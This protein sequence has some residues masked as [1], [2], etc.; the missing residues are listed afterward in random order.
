MERTDTLKTNAGNERLKRRYFEY[1]RESRQLDMHS[2]D[3]DAMAISRFEEHSGYRDFGRY[4]KEMAIAFKQH[5]AKQTNA[6]TG[7]VL[8]KATIYS[9]LTALRK[10]FAWLAD[11]P[12]YR[13]RITETAADYF[14]ASLKDRT[15][16][17]ASGPNRVPT[18][19]QIRTVLNSMPIKTPVEKRDR[20]IMAF[21]ILTGARDDAI[22]SLRLGHLDMAEKRVLQDGRSVRTKFSKSIETY[23]FPVGVDIESMLAAWVNH[24]TTVEQFSANDPLFPPVTMGIGDDGNFAPTGFS[25]ECWANAGAIRAI[26]KKAFSAAG[27]PYF[28]PHSFRKTLT[29]F[30]LELGLGEA[31]IKAWSQ[32]LGH[33]EVLVTMRSYGELP[34]HRQRDLIRAAAHAREDDAIALQLG[35]E[36]LASMRAKKIAG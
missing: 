16:A 12:G 7:E 5:L 22:A 15:A 3:A 6:R 28:N 4:R 35:R 23:F 30:G 9:T 26:F 18:M 8:S 14:K 13:T 21:A 10:F 34:A 19:E 2:I 20:A 27:L 17:R 29:Q 11:Q 33:E 24:L 32:N 25:R 36:M 1:L 31:T